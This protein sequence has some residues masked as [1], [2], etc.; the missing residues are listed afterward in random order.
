M[1]LASSIATQDSVRNAITDA[2]IKH[3]D[4]VGFSGELS[5]KWKHSIVLT[6]NGVS[7][8]IG[9]QR[10]TLSHGRIVKTDVQFNKQADIN[11]A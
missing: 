5:R 10:G 4:N 6:V 3:I 1:V 7:S 8:K 11:P 9:G 2:D